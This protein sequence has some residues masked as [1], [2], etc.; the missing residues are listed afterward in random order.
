MG[1]RKRP[2][3]VLF[4]CTFNSVRS[5]M[6]EA[7]AKHLFGKEIYFQSAGVRRGEL[8]TFAVAVMAEIGIDLSEHEPHTFAEIEDAAFDVI[9]SLSPE[10]HHSAL[11]FTRT[12]AVETL[13][14]PTIDPTAFQGSRETKLGAYREVR[15]ALKR[16]I[17]QLLDKR[18]V[19]V[20]GS[21]VED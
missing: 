8:N 10:A 3:S 11:E 20:P 6:A 14:W 17:R 5:P 9:V 7:I 16:R 12:M 19:A 4:A 18:N 1:V 15:E 13:Y 2:Q 21:G